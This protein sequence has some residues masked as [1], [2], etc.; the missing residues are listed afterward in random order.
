MNSKDVENPR[1][2]D[3]VVRRLP[4]YLTCS[5]RLRQAGVAWVSSPELAEALGLTSSTVRQDLSHIDFSGI[6]KRGYSTAGLETSL[7]VTLGADHEICCVVVGAGNLGRALARHEEFARQ[8]FKICGVFDRSATMIGRKVG[9]LLVQGMAELP[10]VVCGQDVDIGIVAVP[11]VAAQQVAD[12][13][14][15]AGVRGLLNLT[16]AHIIVPKKVSLVDARFL[17]SLRELAYAVKTH[18]PGY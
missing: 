17:A 2:P 16:T 12:H 5:Q 9:K 8:G 7:A 18:E 10:G 15:V 6:S 3:A 13:L 14:I 4:K 1:I 11:H